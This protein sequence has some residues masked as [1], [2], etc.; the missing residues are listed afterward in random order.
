MSAVECKICT[1]VNAAH[2]LQCA[3]CSSLLGDHLE[4]VTVCLSCTYE[5]DADLKECEICNANLQQ[6]RRKVADSLDSTSSSSSSSSLSPPPLP[7]SSSNNCSSKSS[8][9]LQV[10]E[11]ISDAAIDGILELLQE[12]LGDQR[13]ISIFRLVSPLTFISQKL[14]E[15][16]KD[17]SCG[18]RNIQMLC[19]SLMKVPIYRQRLFG[20]SGSVP[21]VY[22]LQSWIEKAWNDGFDVD[23][24][25]Q[26]GGSLLG[27]DTWIGAG[28][29][30][31]LLRYFGIRAVMLD[32]VATGS[33]VSRSDWKGTSPRKQ[34]TQAPNAVNISKW[35][36]GYFQTSR[37]LTI[38]QGL[39][40]PPI[41]FQ[42]DGHSRSVVGYET[43][44]GKKSLLIFDPASDPKKLKENL[45]SKYNWQVMVKR[46]LH[47]IKHGEYQ[48][49]YI[50]GESIMSTEERERSKIFRVNVFNNNNM[51][52]NNTL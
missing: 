22:G 49:V 44:N 30:A 50:A 20:G 42:Q 39:F 45:I 18:Y 36:E 11:F 7:L 4:N 13:S 10:S 24:K 28:E 32:F 23:A 48:F 12:R 51:N 14:S 37:E 19:L 26:L 25:I 41:F 34:S 8:S 21:D 40:I 31:A 46:G 17:W 6:K 5:N 29:A 27:T 33:N 16:G 52:F 35:L 15:A 47:T 1:F 38:E 43:Y 9:T 3:I 2:A